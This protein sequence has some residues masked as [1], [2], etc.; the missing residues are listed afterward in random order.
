MLADSTALLVPVCNGRTASLFQLVDLASVS[1]EDDDLSLTYI[2]APLVG[3]MSFLLIVGL[4]VFISMA[5]KQRSMHG[6]YN[7]QKQEY[8]APRLELEMRIKPPAEER[9]I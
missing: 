4:L 2:L 8:H 7:P 9:L 3:G 6:K 5:K 1:D